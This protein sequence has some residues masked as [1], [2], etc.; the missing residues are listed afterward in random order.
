M[1]IPKEIKKYL[2]QH[3]PDT[4]IPLFWDILSNMQVQMIISRARQTKFGDFRAPSRTKPARI[5]VNGDLPPEA[6]LMT[7]I[8]ELAHA[9]VYFEY[10]NKKFRNIAPHGKEWKTHFKLLM[11]PFLRPDIFSEP[12]L[13]LVKRHMQNPSASSM[14]DRELFEAL[15]GKNNYDIQNQEATHLKDLKNGEVFIFRNR[16]FKR[17]ELLRVYVKCQALDNQQ[18]Y[19]IHGSVEVEMS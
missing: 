11:E 14:R 8:H 2:S 3:I 17:I 9:K 19:R 6:F 12:K 16:R 5:S 15:H 13:S 10:K 18:F 4:A 1:S 7:A